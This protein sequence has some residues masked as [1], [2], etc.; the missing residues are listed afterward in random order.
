MDILEQ[1]FEKGQSY[2][3]NKEQKRLLERFSKKS[4]TIVSKDDL[5]SALE[6]AL[7]KLEPNL[8]LLSDGYKYSHP[9]FYPE[10]LTYMCSYLESR[11]GKFKETLFFGLQ[12]VIKKYLVGRVLS[13][14]MVYE[15]EEKLN[16]KNGVFSG[17]DV[18]PTQKWLDLVRK[19]NGVV[20]VSIKAV[21]EGEIIPVKNVL[22]LIENTDEDFPWIVNFIEGLLLQIWYPITVATLSHE[23]SIVVKDYLKKTGTSPDLINTISSFVLNDFGFRGVSSVESASIGGASHLIRSNGSDNIISSD[24]LI[25]YYNAKQM[26]GKSIRATEH[27]VMTLKGESGEMEMMK[28]VL[29]KFPNGNVACVS[30]SFNIIRACKDYWGGELKEMVLARNGV[31]VIRPDSGDPIQTLKKVFETL[32]DRF[33]FSLNTM[34]FKVLPS[35]VRVIQGDGVNYNSIIDIYEMLVDNNISAENIV[36]GMGGKLLQADINRDTQ[37]FAIK[38]C[39]ATIGGFGFNVFKSPTEID[40]NGEI[41]PS[42]KKSKSGKMKLTK[43]DGVYKTVTSDDPYFYLYVDELVKVFENGELLVDYDFEQIRNISRK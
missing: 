19:H 14:N 36:F 2:W 43:S 3:L 39:F 11:G 6:K 29:T 13:E 18:F 27:S 20:P 32:F 28:R 9:D 33:G 7:S 24:M 15:A 12:Y 1:K 30:D 38:A 31:L 8:I 41:K 35:Q 25:K 22:T 4:E 21:P 26:Y 37:N 34:G 17:D 42:F 10:D 23:V 16:G 5:I 40:E